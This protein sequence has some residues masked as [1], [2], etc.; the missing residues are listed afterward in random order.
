LG[1]EALMSTFPVPALL[2]G[3]ARQPAYSSTASLSGYIEGL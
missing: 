3:Y 1:V 2:I